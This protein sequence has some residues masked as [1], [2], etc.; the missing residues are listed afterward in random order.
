MSTLQAVKHSWWVVMALASLA[1]ADDDA[2]PS[3]VA[4]VAPPGDFTSPPLPAGVNPEAPADGWWKKKGA[5]PTGTKL[6]HQKVKDGRRTWVSYA[7]KGKG[8]PKPY[9]AWNDSKDHEAWW[10]DADGKRHGGV[11]IRSF[12]YDTTELYVH[13]KRAGR[14]THR[15]RSGV[16]DGFAH[17]RDD[18]KHGLAHDAVSNIT[19]GGYYVDGKREGTWFVWNNTSPGVVRAVHHY[20]GGVMDGTQRW[21]TRDGQLLAR[22]EL[23]A[24]AGTWT[25]FGPDGTRA[26][27]RC[28]GRDVVEASA[29]DR[30]G[31]LRFRYCAPGTA[32]CTLH[33]TQDGGERQTLGEVPCGWSNVPPFKLW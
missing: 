16:Q 21:W 12:A 33:G 1:N 18:K 19:E 23:V 22:G 25:S 10:T 8:S 14:W 24:G 31:T 3:K 13:G 11:L 9:T 29:R 27:T 28:K 17:Y 20:K 15:A 6:E 5:C 26:E 2:R 30:A 32:G 7:C 4:I